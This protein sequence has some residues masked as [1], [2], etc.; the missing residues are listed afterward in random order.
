MKNKK[1]KI[2]G[3]YWIKNIWNFRFKIFAE[4]LEVNDNNIYCV[5]LY[6]LQDDF[7]EILFNSFSCKFELIEGE[8]TD[9]EYKYPLSRK[10]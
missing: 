6:K 7:P 4:I 8:L 9:A 2:N 5:K 3:C 1:I 10:L